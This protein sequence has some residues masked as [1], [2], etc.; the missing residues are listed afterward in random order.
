MS[1]VRSGECQ[2]CTVFDETL[3]RPGAVCAACVYDGCTL[4]RV[5]GLR[6]VAESKA[7]CESIWSTVNLVVAAGGITATGNL[8]L[9]S[10]CI[11]DSLAIRT[12]T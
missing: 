4:S 2:F 9:H 7:I 10:G 11:S 6:I 12:R 8:V 1:I 3:T 5:Q